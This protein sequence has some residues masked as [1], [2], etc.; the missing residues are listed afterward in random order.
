MKKCKLIAEIGGNHRGS[1]ETAKDMIIASA[2]S[3]ADVVKFQKRNIFESLTFEER[4][5][6]H[7]NEKNSYG[8]TYGE[9]R[10]FLE[11]DLK[12]HEELKKFCEAQK[13]IYS[14]SVWDLDSAKQIISLSPIM[15]KIPSAL[16]SNFVLLDYVYTKTNRNTE[17]HISLGM[18]TIK[19]RIN[20]LDWIKEHGQPK[21]TVIYHCVSGYPVPLKDSNILEIKD[22]AEIPDFLGVGYSSHENGYLLDLPSYTL[23]AEYIERHFTLNKEWKGT[24]HKASLTPKEFKDLRKKLDLIAPAVNYAK[25]GGLSDIE[26][27][28]KIKLRW[29]RNVEH[30]KV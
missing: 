6:P 2:M 7:P 16:A 14:C 3:G 27:K 12:Q 13:V 28:S 22:L 30:C 29:D 18:H 17:I 23:G 9:H 10:E 24:D 8:K 1:I 5:A 4:R 20:I 26:K 15:I 21:R 11:F 25:L 19:E